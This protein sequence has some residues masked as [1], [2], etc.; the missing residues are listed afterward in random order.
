MYKLDIPLN[1]KETAAI[2]RRRRAEKE[3]QG[4]VFNSKYRQIGVD[5]EALDQ[6]VEDRNWLE[7]LEQKRA[8]AFAKDAIR[9]DT[10]AQLLER[11]QEYDERENNRAVNEF[12][13]L[14][15]QPSAQREWDLNDPDYLK[16]DMPARV[17]DDDPRCGIASLQKFKGEDL[18]SPA[19]KK[20]QQ[21][22]LRE[23][24]RL[25]QENQRHAQ[26]QQRAADRLY[27]MK[28]NELDQ[29]SVE[30]QRA[31]EECRKAINESI[32]NY[33]DALLRETEERRALKKRQEEYDNYAELANMIS[34]DLLTE[35]PDQ[36]MSQFGPHRVVPDR[37][38][39]MNEDQLRR[40]REEQQR[41]IE[42]K[43]RRTEEEQQRED[44][45]NR[46]RFAEAKAGMIIE[47]HVEHEKR[48]FEHDVYNDNQRL[49]NEQRNL[50]AYL[51][52][53]VYTNQ[54]TAA[55]FM[56]FNTSSR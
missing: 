28:Q 34:C 22:Q 42:E 25:Q 40:I 18:N 47:K 53:V 48:T 46:R 32:K 11:R 52:R 43:K 19:R 12:R 17:A 36:A 4:R 15:Q 33:N 23:W 45:W 30:L 39:G 27:D 13:A 24:S 26:Q 6:Q 3:R 50:K 29:R 35:N 44:E 38:K 16:K 54:P 5:K 31:E 8:D 49:A 14:H 41:Q 2:E 9:N 37:W 21:E 51:D 10:V 1:L 7:D 20:Y 56:Q 55:Y